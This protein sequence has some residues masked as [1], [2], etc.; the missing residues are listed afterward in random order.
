MKKALMLSGVLFLMGNTAVIAYIVLA[1]FLT[2][3]KAIT[4]T[5]NSYGEMYADIGVV[6]F[7]FCAGALSLYHLIKAEL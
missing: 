1:A 5:I 6:A 2:P 7:T 3:E 4:V